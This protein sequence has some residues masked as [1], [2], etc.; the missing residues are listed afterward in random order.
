MKKI[1][2]S[3]CALVLLNKL[4]SQQTEAVTELIGTKMPDVSFSYYEGNEKKEAMLTDFRGKFIILDFWNIGCLA[5]IKAMPKMDSLQKAFSEKLQIILVT[6]NSEKEVKELFTRIKFPFPK[7]LSVKSDST[8]TSL[9]PHAAE[10]FH[11]WIDDKGVVKYITE[12]YNA[13]YE[14]INGFVQEKELGLLKVVK[15]ENL[16][17]EKSLLIES[18]SLLLENL[19]SYSVLLKG[20][21]EKTLSKGF[22]TVKSTSDANLT[23]IRALNNPVASLFIFAF[24]NELYDFEIN[25][26]NFRVNNRILFE[27]RNN[28]RFT[29]PSDQNKMDDWRKNN[30]FSYELYYPGIGTDSMHKIMQGDLN[31]YFDYYGRIEK[32]KIKCLVLVKSKPILNLKSKNPSVP[33][34]YNYLD[35]GFVVQNM[36]ISR[37]LLKALTNAKQ[38]LKTPVI[39]ETKYSENV[40]L[41]LSANPTDDLSS[42]RKALRKIGMDLITVER[43]IKMLIITDKK[44][45]MTKSFKKTAVD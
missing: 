31:K 39:N 35:N 43:E 37:S 26:L 10:P 25:P 16:T 3:I 4:C 36:P 5:C 41:F 17:V 18:S 27:T 15:N 23:S 21:H 44:P 30:T 22:V 40:D 8:F 6:K 28:E 12:G 42:L 45:P 29:M 9:F 38:D 14:H 34:K 13:T 32:R 7:L 24:A 11:V 33:G 1:F 2:F 19:H 20:M